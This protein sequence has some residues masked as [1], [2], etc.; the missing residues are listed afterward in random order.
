MNWE[1][2]ADL[3]TPTPPNIITR[4]GGPP[5]PPVGTVAGEDLFDELEH[6]EVLLLD[7]SL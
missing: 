2:S 6:T 3:P 4:K 7:P 1:T 5:S